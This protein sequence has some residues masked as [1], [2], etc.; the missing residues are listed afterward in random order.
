MTSINS[1]ATAFKD[2]QKLASGT[3]LEVALAMKAE[4]EINPNSRIFAFLDETGAMIDFD[5]SGNDAQIIAKLIKQLPQTPT[6]TQIIQFENAK[7]AGRPKLGVIAKE[8]TLLPRHWE[9][10]A[11]QSGGA[12]ATI[13]KLVE[14]AAKDTIG[15]EIR[16]KAQEATYRFLQNMAGDFINYEEAI[17][18]IFADD[19]LKFKALSENWAQDI[20]DH[21]IKLF[22]AK[23]EK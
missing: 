8:V 14:Q 16:R 19:E 4:M 13:R 11:K 10:L 23:L 9:W 1:Q 21:S 6:K 22:T 3:L 2:N 18:A 15:I 5:L 17:R 7:S 20:R 12:S